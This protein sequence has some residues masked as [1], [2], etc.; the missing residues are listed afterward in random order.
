VK[1]F[2][3]IAALVLAGCSG[4]AP[5]P[6]DAASP[7][8]VAPAGSTPPAFIPASPSA[9]PGVTAPPAT[10]T[11]TLGSRLTLLR[12]GGATVDVNAL[13]VADPAGGRAEP[14]EGSR[15]VA[16]RFELSNPEGPTYTETPADA[17]R[18][19]DGDGGVYAGWRTDPVRPGFGGEVSIR[20]GDF[21]RGFVTFS[22]PLGATLAAV[23]FTPDARSAPDTGEW[24]L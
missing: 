13:E 1:A 12:G 21:E 10:R 24:R 8:P 16:V 20:E 14:P 4:G 6:N 22:V 19:I 15:W 17:A 23:R 18:L 5:G 3:L 11:T 7:P 9:V 2:A